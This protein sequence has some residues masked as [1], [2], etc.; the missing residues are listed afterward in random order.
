MAMQGLTQRPVIAD[1]LTNSFRLMGKVY[2]PSSGL[3]T[4]MNDQSSAYAE[5]IQAQMM[6]LNLSSRVL[7]QYEVTRLVKQHVL[8]V[9]ISRREDVG[10]QAFPRLGFAPLTDYPIEI[11]TDTYEVQ[12]IVQWAGRLDFSSLMAVD[13]PDFFPIYKATITGIQV[14]NLVVESPIVLFNRTHISAI[15]QVEASGKAVT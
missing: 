13:N 14:T 7:D 11:V 1:F 12:G 3:L 4:L 10:P 9:C 6:R 15:T 8:A 5:V 2:I